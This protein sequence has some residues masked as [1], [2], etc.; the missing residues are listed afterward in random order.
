MAS[1]VRQ[2]CEALSETGD[3]L[4]VLGVMALAGPFD[5]H[6]AQR[7]LSGLAVIGLEGIYDFLEHAPPQVDAEQVA[8]MHDVLD[9]AF[10]KINRRGATERSNP[11][12]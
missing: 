1:K 10:P 11:A 3:R 2:V 6:L 5:R 8:R 9:A 7:R 12:Q 4:P